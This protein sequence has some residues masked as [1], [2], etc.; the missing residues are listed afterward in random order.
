[1]VWCRGAQR[2]GGRQWPL[3]GLLLVASFLV[4][5]LLM[6]V[7]AAAAPL[8]EAAAHHASASPVEGKAT[9]AQQTHGPVPEHPENCRIGQSAAPRSGDAFERAGQNLGAA[10]G[11]VDTVA[12]P[13]EDA[14][15]I[16]WEEPRRPPGTLRAHLQVYRI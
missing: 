5:D 10:P 15:S 7:E 16:Q 12:A 11:I 1:M 4:H 8:P 13:G 6:A 9:A 2:I 14:G 3:L